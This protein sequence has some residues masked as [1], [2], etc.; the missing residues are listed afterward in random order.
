[1]ST[2]NQES[3]DKY[4]AMNDGL[5]YQNYTPE[6]EEDEVY[7]VRQDYGY[8][9]IV[10]SVVQIIILV[11]MMWQ[12]SIA[13]MS[14]N[15]MI[16]PYPDAL[17]EWGGKNSVLIL[18][19]GQWYRLVTPI[20]LHAGII[21]LFCNV[22]VQL[23]TGVFF[24]KEWGTL[25][26]L[27]VYLSSAVGSSILSVIMM[28]EAVSVGSSGAVCG[29]F[30]AK[31]AEVVLRSCEPAETREA[32]VAQQVR[33]E[34][35][36]VVTCSV[37]VIL[38]FSFVPFVDWA[39]HLGG[40]VAGV[41]VGMLLFSIDHHWIC[42]KLVWMILGAATTIVAFGLALKAMMDVEPPQELRDVCGYYQQ[43]FEDYECN[44]MREEYF[45]NGG[46][47]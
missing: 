33:K 24:E 5:K 13:P 16:G 30:G 6:D 18:E 39:A 4:V 47:N 22:A 38:A 3:N 36:F 44:C 26:W 1:M 43:N 8:A 29:L 12:C 20:L 35:C 17:S 25:R 37:I 45:N 7:I 19:D 15:P 2:K 9:S 41:F 27:I 42:G 31:L 11:V 32:R 23:E 28:P 46:A 40:L 14:I 34:Q 10:F 21:H